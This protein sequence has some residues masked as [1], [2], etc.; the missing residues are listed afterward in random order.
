MRV[1][2]VLMWPYRNQAEREERK[3]LVQAGADISGRV[4]TP[5]EVLPLCHHD[6][7]NYI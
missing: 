2:G 7:V 1:Y 3:V 4:F 5:E 6:N